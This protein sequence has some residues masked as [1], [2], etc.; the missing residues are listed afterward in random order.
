[1]KGKIKEGQLLVFTL[2]GGDAGE[3]LSA[4]VG[5]FRASKDIDLENLEEIDSNMLL[6]DCFEEAVLPAKMFADTTF[7]VA[8]DFTEVSQWE[9]TFDFQDDEEETDESS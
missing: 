5:V 1:M 8:Q 3:G 7:F 4:I 6:S 9:T 2:H